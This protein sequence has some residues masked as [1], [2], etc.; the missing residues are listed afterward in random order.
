MFDESSENN[1]D[2]EIGNLDGILFQIGQKNV[3]IVV[4]NEK[5][6]SKQG[7]IPVKQGIRI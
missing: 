4:V 2:E 1:D 6:N 5:M 3:R 7:N